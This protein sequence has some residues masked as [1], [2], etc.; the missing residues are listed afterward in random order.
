MKAGNG[1]RISIFKAY[2]Q[3]Q[4]DN[5]GHLERHYIEKKGAC[6]LFDQ[7]KPYDLANPYRSSS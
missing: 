2:I 5:F 3:E 6:S 7:G 4:A 1:N